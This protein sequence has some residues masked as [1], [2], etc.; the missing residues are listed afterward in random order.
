LAL[1][2]SQQ[3]HFHSEEVKMAKINTPEFAQEN[4]SYNTP[5]GKPLDHRQLLIDLVASAPGPQAALI[6]ESALKNQDKQIK[7]AMTTHGKTADEVI[8][9]QGVDLNALI[10]SNGKKGNFLYTPFQVNQQSGEITPESI[11]GGLFKSHPDDLLKMVQANQLTNPNSPENR[12]RIARAKYLESG[13]NNAGNNISSTPG[14]DAL[15]SEQQLQAL[16]MARQKGGVRGVQNFLPSIVA[17][18][19]SGV[20]IDQIEDKLRYSQQSSGMADEWRGAAQSI[21]AD[22][23]LGQTN[24][25][26]DALD[27][28]LQK[29]DIDGGK[30]YLKRIALE[31]APVDQ[32]TPV[33]GKER[34][35]D[36]LREIKNDLRVL[37]NNG[38]PTGFLSG[39]LENILQRVGQV[40][41]PE[42]RKVAT[43]I[44]VA[45]MNYRKSITGAAFAAQETA[46]YNKIFPGINK[47]GD[48]NSANIDALNEVFTG[49]V[50]KFYQQ[51]MGSGNYKKLFGG[52]SD[53][54]GSSGDAPKST[55]FR[56]IGVRNN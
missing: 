11:L 47:V 49:D 30:N 33:M 15:S 20:P 14:F 31:K 26:M 32:R 28:Y 9:S 25:Q 22:S 35:V 37:E 48:L 19:N 42:M 43:K 36:L 34:T 45:L 13:G 23:P 50:N 44:G 24:K 10:S 8:K 12:E 52:N 21:L 51:S 41:N 29:G 46:D 4:M 55:G 3:V 27:D 2:K 7:E 40:K 53:N 17:Q 18:M 56:V 1:L 5:D 6:T 39:N 38:V 54:N 16:D